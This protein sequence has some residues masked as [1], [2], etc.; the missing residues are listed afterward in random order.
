M[1]RL[2]VVVSGDPSG[3]LHASHF[4][5]AL[6]QQ[7]PDIRVAAVGGSLSRAAAD[8]FIEDLAARG[9]TGF[10]KPIRQLGFLRHLLKDLRD[11][12]VTRRPAA[13]VC[14]D[15]YGFNRRV[16]G[17]AKGAG[18]PAFYYVSPQ[19]WASRPGRI[20]VLK[21]LVR[22][23]LVIFPF[24]ERL[25][26]DAGVPVEFVGHPLLDYVPA[27]LPT[28]STPPNAV[29]GLLPGSR[30]SE[31]ARHLPVF[32]DAFA[33]LRSTRP[34]LTGVLFAAPSQPDSAYGPL[35]DGVTLVRETDYA[36][37]RALD[38]AICS[39]G[40]ATLENALLGVPMVVVYKMGWVEYRI[41]RAVVRVPYI[42]MPNLLA[43]KLVVPELIQGAATSERIVAEVAA[44]LD[45]S[46]GAGSVRAELLAI[47]QSLAAEG[48]G[49]AAQRAARAVSDAIG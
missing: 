37:R 48:A 24:E 7:A 26:A 36:R 31:L 16:L 41:A 49:S 15:F 21:T 30:A 12:F 43:G 47:R 42:G 20:K 25:Y 17:A 18:I 39:S 5:I 3:D 29:V 40:T 46:Y 33:R 8:E 23:M 45:D 35:P 14:V 27:P 22:K 19:V 2:I 32:Y 6:K 38:V 11:L 28:R 34:T 1:T 9:V 13:L 4:I 44:L 10:I